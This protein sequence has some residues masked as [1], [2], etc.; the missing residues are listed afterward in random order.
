[1]CVVYMCV[2]MCRSV[3][4]CVTKAKDDIRVFFNCSLYIGVES[5][6]KLGVFEL[7]FLIV[8]QEQL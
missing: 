1:M 4:M 3:S 5:L 7:E 2:P 8:T 6:P